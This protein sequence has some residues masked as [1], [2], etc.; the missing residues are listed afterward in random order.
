MAN[1]RGLSIYSALLLLVLAA[2]VPLFLLVS[3]F[4]YSDYRST[5]ND[6]YSELLNLSRALASVVDREVAAREAVAQ[7]LAKLPALQE[8]DLR[9]FYDRAERMLELLPAGSAF[10]LADAT[11]QQLINTNRPFG[12]R[13]PLRGDLTSVRKVFETRDRW[14]SDVFIGAISKQPV[15]G[16]DIPVFRNNDVVY[17]L[18]LSLP[19]AS[20]RDALVAQRLP[21]GWVAAILDRQGTVIARN[22]D[23]AAWVGKKAAATLRKDIS[24]RREGFSGGATLEGVQV[25]SAFTTSSQTGWTV[26]IG[27]PEAG[28]TDPLRQRIVLLGSLIVAVLIFGILAAAA[29]GRRVTVPIAALAHNAALF[30]KGEPIHPVPSSIREIRRVS[31]ELSAAAMELRARETALKQSEE[32]KAAVIE[33]ALD[34]IVNMN[35][36]GTVVEFN[37]GAERIFGLPRAEAIGRSLSELF[38]PPEYRK[39]HAEGLAHYLATGEARVLGKRLELEA[40]RSDGS[41]FPVELAIAVT[42]LEGKRLFTGHMRDIS[43]RKS[44]ETMRDAAEQSL[45]DMNVTL[46]QRVNERTH[47]LVAANEKLQSEIRTREEAEGQLRQMQKIEAIGQLTGGIA[48]DFNNMLA[49]V[50]GSLRLLQKRLEKGE[51]NV[52]R[53]IDGAIDGAE[54]AAGLT[55]RL[56][57]FS[58][59]QTLFPQSLDANKIISGLSEFF[60]RT[61]PENVEIETVLAGGLWR[62]HCD[63]H[64]LENAVLN[65]VLNSRDAMPEGGKLTIETANAW[66]DDA[67]ASAHVDVASGQYVMIGVSDSGTG[68]PPD[69]AARAFDPFFTTKASGQGTGLGLSQVYGFIKQSGGHVKIYSEPSQ[70]TAVKIYLPRYLGKS[71]DV[72]SPLD[73]ADVPMA[74][75]NE[76]ILL[77]EDEERVRSLTSE[78]LQDLGYRVVEAEGAATALALLEEHPDIV[79]LFTD[80]MMPGMNGRQLA[81]AAAQRHPRLKVL[82]TTGYTR[83]AIVHNGILDAGV[84]VLLKP[85]TLEALASKVNQ[86]LCPR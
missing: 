37:P 17:E 47:A 30:A 41:R 34:A 31:E 63:P 13:L 73:P 46:E 70:G 51:T 43:E 45:R 22:L 69:V 27:R 38:I 54:R 82:F 40:I 9:T 72:V 48:H 14:L 8:G 81:E 85:Y 75:A 78:M 33:S 86:V 5:R 35:E 53:F 80:V 84:S 49:I 25:I 16:L 12:D 58:R 24:E 79:L 21:S 60:R 7:V 2:T 42:K 10:I 36:E 64:Q 65:L 77:V 57:A 52:Q 1:I 15:V 74:P 76:K 61:I 28:I 67:Y 56:L 32:A 59:Q 3:W 66:L 55:K 39:S 4:A 50:I 83:N 18:A 62:S 19:V 26:A 11:G 29:F 68:M 23:N 44:A 71:V 6:A 20:L